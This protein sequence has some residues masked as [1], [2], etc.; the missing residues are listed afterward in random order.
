MGSDLVGRAVS[1]IVNA[2]FCIE[3]HSARLIEELAL[4]RRVKVATDWWRFLSF[5]L[6]FFLSYFLDF[7]S[8]CFCSPNYVLIMEKIER[9]RKKE[10]IILSGYEYL[11]ELKFHQSQHYRIVYVLKGPNKFVK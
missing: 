7:S 6:S 4:K 11:H 2:L 9:K 5:F 10:I 8:V 3:M 1:F